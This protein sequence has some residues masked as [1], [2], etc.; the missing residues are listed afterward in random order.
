[1]PPNLRFGAAH[2]GTPP[3]SSSVSIST[4]RLLPPP[5]A[6]AGFSS[7]AACLKSRPEFGRV[8]RPL[9]GTGTF[10][11]PTHRF[12]DLLGIRSC[13]TRARPRQRLLVSIY[14]SIIELSGTQ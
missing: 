6:S 7:A 2:V 10:P 12:A 9:R 4:N 1:M 5:S 14:I 3:S 13:D 11:S 8:K